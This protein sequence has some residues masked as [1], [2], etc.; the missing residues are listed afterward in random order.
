MRYYIL[1]LGAPGIKHLILVP[2]SHS[3]PFS[4]LD[5]LSFQFGGIGI[6]RR[7][8]RHRWGLRRCRRPCPLQDLQHGDPLGTRVPAVANLQ[9]GVGRHHAQHLLPDLR[10]KPG[11]LPEHPAAGRVQVLPG[12]LRPFIGRGEFGLGPGDPFLHLGLGIGR[13][14]GQGVPFGLLHRPAGRERHLL[15]PALL[16]G[17]GETGGVVRELLERFVELRL[18][19]DGEGV[20]RAVEGD[21]GGGHVHH[22]GDEGG[23]GVPADV[24]AEIRGLAA[25]EVRALAPS[26]SR[27]GVG[28]FLEGFG[29][30]F[31][32]PN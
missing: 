1:N 5:L 27:E 32:T 2:R 7:L 4:T 19:H 29:P 14:P 13:G 3:P 21:E 23:V 16:E 12:D 11:H 6:H 20:A 30:F 31:G 24:P 25:A 28:E 22:G 18:L 15:L 8:R 10:A 9:P 26:E 17:H